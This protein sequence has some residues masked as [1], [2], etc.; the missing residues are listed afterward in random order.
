MRKIE[1]ST[2]K[3]KKIQENMK[4]EEHIKQIQDNSEKSKNTTPTQK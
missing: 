3:Y 2:C 4:F 1:Q